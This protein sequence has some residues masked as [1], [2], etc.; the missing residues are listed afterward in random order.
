VIIVPFEAIEERARERA[1][2]AQALVARLP[3]PKSTDEL[4]AV[5]DDRYLSMM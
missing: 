2:G 3:L 4:R 5:P 1:G